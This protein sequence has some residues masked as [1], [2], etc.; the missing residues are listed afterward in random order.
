MF[1]SVII[2]A[3]YYSLCTHI[4]DWKPVKKVIQA[5]FF[6]IVLL[7]I[8]QL[9]GKD[10]LLNFKEKAPDVLNGVLTPIVGTIGNKMI[11]SSFICILAP[12][13]LF[14]PLNWILLI[15]VS[16]ISWSSGAVLSIGAGL[17]VYF[18]A[19][20]KRFRILIIVFAILLPMIF[21]WQ[22][23]KIRTFGSKAG[24]L[25][26]YLKTLEL[27]FKRPLGYG[28][29]SYK[30]MFPILCGKEIKKQQPGKEWDTAHCDWLQVLFETGIPGFVLYMGWL[31]EIILNVLK[32]KNYG[33]IAGLVIIA[34]NMMFHFPT[35]LCQSAFLILMF[36]A[37]CSQ[38]RRLSNV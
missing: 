4:E 27:S 30:V 28:I 5:I 7:I 19:K 13:L 14:T 16:F 3:Y 9:S 29:A 20:F 33:K 21:A 10:T 25:P 36:L 31:T 34:A 17:A 18:L 1:W 6:F 23:G 22:T 15:I 11:A 26:V 35:R 32:D 8:M 38:R 2:C 24:R 37:Y 12:F